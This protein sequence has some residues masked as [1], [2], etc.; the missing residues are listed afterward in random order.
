M[1][2]LDLLHRSSNGKTIKTFAKKFDLVYFGHV[3]HRYDE[4]AVVRGVTAS[5]SHV[6]RHFAVGN[7]K[8]RDI[9]LL[10]R[11]NSLRFPGKGENDYHWV[12][13]QVDLG[14]ATELPHI[15][16]DAHHHDEVFYSNLYIN[17]A[18]FQVATNLFI[19]HDGKFAEHFIPYAP[20]DKFDT[21][22]EVMSTSVTG[23]LAH[24][25][26]H[27]DYEFDGSTIYIYNSQPVVHEKDLEEMA[28]VGLW[29]ADKLEVVQP[30]GAADD[31]AAP[32]HRMAH[33]NA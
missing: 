8:G 3:D 14:P 30:T 19:N 28:R 21:V 5:T 12:I 10:E 31:E 24:H 4:H 20:S 33:E 13:V 9:S 17:F 27:F 1:S 6:D 29:L 32:A 7:V 15:F 16:L 2:I 23:M 26:S 22:S 18:N 11:T 25:F